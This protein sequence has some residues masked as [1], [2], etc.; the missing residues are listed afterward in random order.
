MGLIDS[1]KG[2]WSRHDE[3]LEEEALEER[4]AETEGDDLS[5]TP[6][7]DRYIEDRASEHEDAIEHEQPE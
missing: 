1:L 3:R 6:G 4:A 7:L 2:M 5:L